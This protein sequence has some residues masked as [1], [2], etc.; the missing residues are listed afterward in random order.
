M[1][2]SITDVSASPEKQKIKK[3]HNDGGSYTF[4]SS[5]VFL[6][7]RRFVRIVRVDSERIDGR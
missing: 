2:V 6:G 3:K 1:Q 4:V 5:F 7:A